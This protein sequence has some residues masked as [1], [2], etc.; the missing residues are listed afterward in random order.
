M[1]IGKNVFYDKRCFN[2]E[3]YS[4]FSFQTGVLLLIQSFFPK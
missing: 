3:N 4:L 2:F 1:F